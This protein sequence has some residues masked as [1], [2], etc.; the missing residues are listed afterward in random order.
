[1]TVNGN[2]DYESQT[3]YD[4]VISVDDSEGLSRQATITV[5]LRDVAFTLSNTANVGDGGNLE[6]SG[7]YSVT[8]AEV[9]GMTY[10]FVGSQDDSGVSVFSVANNG[11]LNNVDNVSDSGNLEL[12]IVRSVTT[13]EV[14]G[15]TYL[16]VA[17]FL[18]HGVSAFS[19]ANNGDSK[20]RR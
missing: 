17:G 2:L 10:L 8:T 4:L 9:G 3:S 13:A 16:F 11:S 7:A 19:V 12:N 6:I 20:Q 14:G 1:M 5:N 18:D 15:M